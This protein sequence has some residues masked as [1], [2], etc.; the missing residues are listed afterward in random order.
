MLCGERCHGKIFQ[1]NIGNTK[2]AAK[3]WEQDFLRDKSQVNDEAYK[4]GV[5]FFLKQHDL[6]QLVHRDEP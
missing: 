1:G 5:L 3:D 4:G 6:L 2:L